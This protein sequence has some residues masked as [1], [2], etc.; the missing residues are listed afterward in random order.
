V[1]VSRGDGYGK[2][3]G[4]TFTAQKKFNEDAGFIANVTFSR[5]WDT[6]SSERATPTSGL[7]PFPSSPFGEIGSAQLPN[8]AD[9]NSS[10]G[11]SNNDRLM[12]FNAVAYFPVVVGINASI[13]FN[14]QTGL[15]FT[16]YD[17]RDLNGDGVANHFALSGRNTE[18]QP[19][20]SQM[21]LRLTRSFPIF[22]SVRLEGILDVYNVF[23]TAYNA[24]STSKQV[25]TNASG[26][27]NANY[28]KQDTLDLNTREVQV[29]IRLKF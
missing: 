13:R 26:I 2:Y 20:S 8:P 22:R 24:I 11:I 29:G 25:A 27:V 4:L 14:Y 16:A 23:N 1:F 5:A 6:T 15:P 9:V 17:G 21:D 10:Y 19:N 3:M 28:G 7:T 18:R 12:V